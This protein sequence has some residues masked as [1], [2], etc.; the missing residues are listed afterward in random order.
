MPRPRGQHE[1][2][3]ICALSGSLHQ[4]HP[5]KGWRGAGEPI[6]FPVVKAQ[7]GHRAATA[8]K[9]FKGHQR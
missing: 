2:S 8:I 4:R 1:F 9:N 3:P 5:D 6:E 7:V